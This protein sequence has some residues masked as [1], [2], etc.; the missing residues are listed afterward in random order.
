MHGNWIML[1]SVKR[2]LADDHFLGT[3]K[4]HPIYDKNGFIKQER[5]VSIVKRFLESKGTRPLRSKKVGLTIL[6]E[7]AGDSF[8]VSI[9]KMSNVSLMDINDHGE[10]ALHI[11]VKHQR[12]DNVKFLEE[13]SIS[14][15]AKDVNGQTLLHHAIFGV[16][17]I[18]QLLE[19]HAVNWVKD[20]E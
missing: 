13:A 9:P 16:V 7:A 8:S 6:F 14:V 18:V 5:N 2:L 12:L 15:D 1:S 3:R 20:K 10:T 19:A 11:A 17:E 4:K